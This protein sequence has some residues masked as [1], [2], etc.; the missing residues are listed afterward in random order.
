MLRRQFWNASCATYPSAFERAM[1][2]IE[3]QSKTAHDHLR[4][5]NPKLWSKSHFATASKA[6]N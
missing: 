2:A 5:F 1:K 6:D 3:R 4:K